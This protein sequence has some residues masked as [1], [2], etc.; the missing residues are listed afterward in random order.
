[1]GGDKLWLEKELSWLAFNERVLQEAMDKEVPLVERVRFLGIVSSNQDEFFKVRVAEVKRRVLI[2]KEY[3]GDPQA[4]PLLHHIQERLN[5]TRE[6]FDATYRELMLAL[7][8]H[9]IFLINE[10]QISERNR[11]WLKQFF[12]DKILRH[13]NP[14]LLTEYCDPVRFLKDQY[15]Y[16]AIEMRQGGQVLK[17]AM[18]EIPTDHLPRFIPLP[19]GENRRKKELIILDNIIRFCLDDIFHGFF[20][21]DEIAAYSFKMTRDAE[22]DLSSQLD[23]SLLEKMSSGLKQRLTAMPVRFAYDMEMPRAMVRFLTGKLRMSSFDSIMPGGRYH[24]FKDFIGFPNVGRAYL[25]NGKLPA[26]DSS[27]FNRHANAFDAI[28]QGDILLYYPYHKF[29]H[30]TE[31]LRQAAF[32]P[33][34]RSI[35]INIYRVAS[36]SRV[37]DSLITA[38]NNG[39][40]VTV[41]VELQARFDEAA[42]IQWA[43]R[44]TEAGVRVLF[45]LT[46]LKIHSKLCLISRREGEQLV[47]YAH[48]GTG[49]FNEKTA[50]IYTDFSLFTCHPEIANEVSG[51]FEFIDQPYRHPRFAHLLVSPIN[52]RRHLYRLIDAEIANARAGLS[53]GITVKVNNLVDKEVV[54][55]LYSASQAGVPVRLIVRGMCSLVPG[56]AGISDNISVISIVDRFLEHPRVMCFHNNGDPR[57]FIASADWMTRNLDHRIEVGTPIYDERLKK[58]ILDILNIQLNDT[59]KARIIDAEQSN[60][61]VP[62]GNRRKIRS[63]LA[64]YDYLKRQE[65]S[66]NAQ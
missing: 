66:A 50:K 56:I 23:L 31:L 60:A 40:R 46:S 11:I 35:K 29:L 6:V 48:I 36:Q 58:R 12:R 51:V 32:D 45:G 14:I 53:T 37:I 28:R 8:R 49:N 25:V 61:Y 10:N 9:N 52:F 2:H 22:F 3:G 24:N 21:Y 5:Q 54:D 38:A 30:F 62:R 7:A 4:E 41:V 65:Q 20:E 43:N 63:Q 18:L 59:V 26:L 47:R 1:M 33:A 39:K 27:E 17:Y 57:V 34:V 64:I 42:N 44:L 55:R 13:I 19:P 16:L 15:T